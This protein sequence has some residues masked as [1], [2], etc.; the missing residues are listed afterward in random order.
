MSILG[1][2]NGQ[3]SSMRWIVQS[4]FLLTLLIVLPGGMGYGLLVG[5][6]WQ[7]AISGRIQPG[8]TTI[9][10]LFLMAFSLDSS[11]LREAFRSPIPVVWGTVVNIGLIPLMAW[12]VALWFSLPDFALGLMIAAVV[13]CTLATASVS[14]RQA[15]GND[16]ISL[17]I[18]LVTN[19]ASV[20]LTPLWLK[21][22]ISMEAD[23]DPWPVIGNLARTVLLPTIIGQA[24]RFA[25]LIGPIAK[26]YRFQIGILAQCLV[27]LIVFKA[28]ID[29]GG[30]LQDH[31]VWPAG[32]EFVALVMACVV[33]HLAAMLVAHIGGRLSGIARE[34]RIA[35]L[36]A[37]SQKT[38]PVGL[39]V[40]AM[41]AITHGRSLPFITFP[42]LIFHA[43]QLLLDSAI[44]DR[45]A[46]RGNHRLNPDPVTAI[47]VENNADR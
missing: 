29:A 15:K 16:A 33:V 19:L 17:L 28:A 25:P 20:F 12:P 26:A 4:W 47:S 31:D 9:A 24:A 8:P 40:A 41:P 5:A 36:F 23:I 34:D 32:F 3:A 7:Q 11:R 30:R 27:L 2:S 6:E 38:L 18:T 46:S 44:A 42:I 21:W 1:M 13:P 43:C 35:T 22:T 14:T 10:I 39:L 45:L 37:G